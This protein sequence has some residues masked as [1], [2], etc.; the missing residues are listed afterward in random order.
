MSS[1]GATP[2]VLGLGEPVQLTSTQVTAPQPSIIVRNDV[3]NV[4]RTSVTVKKEGGFCCC[5]CCCL[6]GC[7]RSCC[8]CVACCCPRHTCCCF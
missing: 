4:N 2:I 7:I 8:P 5:D 1:V 3:S 6:G